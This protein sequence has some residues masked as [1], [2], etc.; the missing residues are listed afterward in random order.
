MQ[1]NIPLKIALIQRGVPL[2][3]SARKVGIAPEKLS[4]IISGVVIPRKSEKS[5]LAKLCR[6]KASELFPAGTRNA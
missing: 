4:R 5:A 3:I 1:R 2:Y 6:R